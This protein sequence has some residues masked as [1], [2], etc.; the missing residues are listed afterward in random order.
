MIHDRVF[1]VWPGSGGAI[2]LEC[3]DFDEYCKTILNRSIG[4][5]TSS[6]SFKVLELVNNSAHA[7]GNDIA[8]S[9]Y[10][11]VALGGASLSLV[12]MMSVVNVSL[13]LKDAF[14]QIVKGTSDIPIPYLLESWSCSSARCRV[15]HSLSPLKFM[16][17][18][19]ESGIADSLILKQTIPC[20]RNSSTVTLHF[21]LYGSTSGLLVESFTV[22]CL[23]CGTSQV[24]VNEVTTNKAPIWICRQCLT[25]QYV[26]NQN[27]DSCQDCPAGKSFINL[28]E[29]LKHAYEARIRFPCSLMGY[30]MAE[31]C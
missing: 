16:S 14:G 26:I 17:F 9:P 6:S 28:H 23:E 30:V 5:P 29:S 11:T 24:R 3:S 1:I 21:S 22:L 27:E 18:D 25:G 20:G 31:F 19:S 8:T 15:Q 7:Y 13:V 12:P 4:L 10:E 2:Y